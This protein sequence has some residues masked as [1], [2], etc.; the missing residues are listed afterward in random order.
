MSRLVLSEVDGSPSQ[1]LQDLTLGLWLEVVDGH[2]H[3]FPSARGENVTISGKPGLTVLTDGFVDES[4][5]VKVAGPLWGNGLTAA[6]RRTAYR[7]RMSAIR[8][9][10]GNVGK[11]VRLVAYPPNEGLTGAETATIDVQFTRLVLPPPGGWESQERI[12]I[13]F[14]CVTDPPGWTIA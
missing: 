10:L 1:E 3:S 9:I 8:T 13:Q 11:V 7:T 12:E 6:L 2:L 14:E 5:T 4:L